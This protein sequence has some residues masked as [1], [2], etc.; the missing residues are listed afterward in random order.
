MHP[1]HRLQSAAGNR[2]VQRLVAKLPR[3]PPP[4]HEAEERVTLL[5][6]SGQV[7]R[8][9]E[10]N[11]S[12]GTL[13]VVLEYQEKISALLEAPDRKA[14]NKLI[15]EVERTFPNRP[16][17]KGVR[18][19]SPSRR[20]RAALKS[21]FPQAQQMI[22]SARN[23]TIDA[24][25]RKDA[26]RPKGEVRAE[27]K[28]G[29]SKIS[30]Y[31]Q[32]LEQQA[33]KRVKVDRNGGGTHLSGTGATAMLVLASNFRDR[34]DVAR[35]LIHEASHGCELLTLDYAYSG[36]SYFLRLPS[37]I[38]LKNADSYAFACDP[39]HSPPCR[40]RRPASGNWPKRP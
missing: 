20:E 13:A 6:L 21:E 26:A 28:A 32:V 7:A 30:G 9:R 1:L 5:A 39:R 38:A 40:D 15:R 18:A 11:P 37:L 3:K 16:K 25:F 4:E 31:L 24:L 22:A 29:L 14:V 27:V 23:D 19:Q 12:P 33:S 35:T 17:E 36:T 8:L 2:A 10:G 34:D